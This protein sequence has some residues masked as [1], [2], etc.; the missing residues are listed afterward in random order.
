MPLD[1]QAS[2]CA[3]LFILKKRFEQPLNFLVIES[4]KTPLLNENG[5]VTNWYNPS[6]NS[7]FS[8]SRFA[9]LLSTVFF[10]PRSSAGKEEGFQSLAVGILHPPPLWTHP[11]TLQLS[12]MFA[13]LARSTSFRYHFKVS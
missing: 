2:L 11:V 5:G 12:K 7:F 8:V 4:P 1:L 6:V 10:L 3:E 13:T 9:F